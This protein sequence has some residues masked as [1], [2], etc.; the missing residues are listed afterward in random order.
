[1]GFAFDGSHAPGFVAEIS[2]HSGAAAAADSADSC[3]DSGAVAG[4]GPDVDWLEASAEG[5]FDGVVLGARSS[6]CLAQL[7]SNTAMV[8]IVRNR[9]IG[10]VSCVA[11]ISY[12]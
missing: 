5:A 4:A 8:A 10:T 9:F 7:A 1:M 2:L 6:E 3:G 11:Q 12:G